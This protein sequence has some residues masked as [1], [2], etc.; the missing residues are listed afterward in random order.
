MTEKS[1]I[2]SLGPALSGDGARRGRDAAVVGLACRFPSA[3]DSAGFWR[4]LASGLN[5]VTEVPAD[6]WD[7]ERWYSP[8]IGAP[9][10]STSRWGA[11]LRG[12]DR[13]DHAFFNVSPREA[14]GMDP[15]QRLLLEETWHCLEDAGISVDTL[16]RARTSVFVGAMAM[17]HYQ[18]VYAPGVETESHAGAGTYAC[19][20]AN[21]VS[22][23]LGLSG[24]SVTL[25]TACSSS[26][27][28]LHHAR[29]AL[30]LD[31]ADY[32]LVAGVSLDFS[33]WK[34]VSFGKARMLSPTGQC[35]TFDKDAD[36][37]VPG[38][39][40]GVIL[41][42][43]LE[44]AERDGS[45]IHGVIRGSAVNHVGRATSLTAPR[46]SAQ[47]D[48]ILAACR[49]ADV[50]PET[51]TYVEAHGTGTSLGDP[52]E[53]AALTEAF[54]TSTERRGFC[55]IG[56]VKTN[57]GHLEAAAGVAGLIKTLL[58]MRHEQVPPTLNLR[59]L[60]PLIDFERS[61]FVPARVAQPW[62]RP[63][64]GP[65][66]AGVSSFGF[67][68]VN[69]H[70]VVEEYRAGSEDA[71]VSGAP[72]AFVLS[73]RTETSLRELK[74][75]WAER[76]RVPGFDGAALRDACLTLQETGRS[77]KR[78]FGAVVRTPAE[79]EAA[80]TKEETPLPAVTVEP[81]AL[82][83]GE[84]PTRGL[85]A[86]RELHACDP[87]FAAAFEQLAAPLLARGGWS[88]AEALLCSGD[89]FPVELR[90][91]L[92][93]CVQCALAE[94]LTQAGLSF[95]LLAGNT[96]ATLVASGALPFDEA[97]RALLPGHEGARVA[98]RRPRRPCVHPVSGEVLEPWEADTALL[99]ELVSGFQ[100]DG[101]GVRKAAAEARLLFGTQHT[102]SRH[103]EE[104]RQPLATVGRTLESLLEGPPP[105][106]ERLAALVLAVSRLRLERKW[107]LGEIPLPGD[108]KLAELAGLVAD[109]FLLPD[110]LVR[111]LCAP[112]AHAPAAAASALARR[113]N[114][115]SKVDACSAARGPG[116]PL[117]G[118]DGELSA[119]ELRGRAV[120]REGLLPGVTGPVLCLGAPSEPL[121]APSL[122]VALEGE[123]EAAKLGA[124]LALWRG[125]LELA[126]ARYAEGRPHQRFR[127]P[128][129]VF[130][131]TPFPPPRVD[132]PLTGTS[133]NADA[134]RSTVMSPR[135]TDS[136]SATGL[137]V[138]INAAP[139]T[140][141][142]IW[143]AS[144]S[145]IRDHRIDGRLLA[146]GAALMRAALFAARR[147]LPGVNALHEV[148]LHTP[149]LVADA[150]AYTV[151]T[152]TS[153]RF[154]V[155][156]GDK[157]L[158]SGAFSA[159][160][161]APGATF[162]PPASAPP[163][164]IAEPSELYSRLAS[165]GYGY[166]E[167]L[168]VVRGLGR[169][170]GK[171]VARL[172]GAPGAGDV[173]AALL[174]GIL[175]CVVALALLDG[176]LQGGS[177]LI[178]F[179]IRRIRFLGP[180]AGAVTVEL[181]TSTVSERGG[182]LQADV[183][184]RTP[185]GT[186]LVELEGAVFRRVPAGFLDA[187][188]STDDV[189]AGIEGAGRDA[190]LD[191]RPV[192]N[193]VPTAGTDGMGQ[194]VP[195]NQRSALVEV[196]A[197]IE[198]TGLYAPRWMAVDA[199]SV[200]AVRGAS[201]LVLPPRADGD[202][203]GRVLAADGPVLVAR[204]STDARPGELHFDPEDPAGW[205][206]LLRRA[207]EELGTAEGPLCIYVLLAADSEPASTASALWQRQARGARALFLLAKAA[208]AS[209]FKS[210]RIAV[211]LRETFSVSPGDTAGGYAA[212][213]VAGAARTI[214]LE[215][216]KLRPVVV[217]FEQ[218]G[219]DDVM[220]LHTLRAECLA[221]S[222]S[223]HVV[224]WRKGR[225]FVPRVARAR[226]GRSASPYRDGGVYV[227]VGGAGGIGR[228]TAAHLA[229]RTRNARIALV[230]RSP[231][232]P[233]IEQVIRELEVSGTG[234][235]VR[236]FPTDVTE[237]D[238][239]A[240]TLARVR[241]SLGPI[242]GV[243]HSGGVLAD[244]LIFSK[245]PDSFDRVLRPKVLGAWLLDELT[246]TEP[247]DF[248]SVYSSV[249]AEVGNVGQVD[250]AAA[251]AFLDAFMDFRRA[252]G[253]PGR[254][255][256]VNWTLWADGGMGRDER[257][258]EQ[259]A[260]RGITL[261]EDAPAFAAL[262]AALTGPEE[263]I[264]VLGPGDGHPFGERLIAADVAPA[265]V[266]PTPEADSRAATPATQPS[267]PAALEGWLTGLIAAR[268]G[269]EPSA[270]DREESFFALGVES[271][272]VKDIMKELDRRYDGLS[273]TL[274]F[275]R[276]NLRELAVY[277][278]SRAPRASTPAV[279]VPAPQPRAEKPSRPTRSAASVP[280]RAIAVIGMSGRFPK[281]PDVET[282]WRNLLAGRDCITEIPADRWDYRR[283]FHA[284]PTH[285][286]TTYGRW[287]GF[288]D[289]VDKFDP[290]FFN[291]SV[292]EAEQMD[293]QQ[294]LFLECAWETLEHAG[295]G[296]RK[297]LREA[298]VGLF[299]GAMWNEYSVITAEQGTFHGRYAGPGSLYWQIA[300][301]VSYFLDLTG[302]SIALDTAC[303]SSLTAVHLACQ[304][305][306]D[307]ES[308]MA[309]AGGV[310]LSLHPDKY[311]YLGQLRFLST[312]GRCR[313]FGEG[314]TGY[315]PGEGVGAVLLK[316]LEQA[317]ADGDTIHAV[318]R[319]T[320]VNHGGRASGFTVPN[321]RQQG[322]LVETALARS[323]VAPTELGYIECHGTGTAL[324]DPIEIQGLTQAFAHAGAAG[325]K[326]VCA[327]GSAKSAIGHLEAAAGIAGLI[328]AA[329]CLQRGKI[330]P[331]LH[332]RTKNPDIDFAAGPFFVAEEV[333]DFPQRE[334]SRFA[335]LSSFGAGG[336]NAHAILQWSAEWDRVAT[337]EARPEL[338]TL[339]A[340]SEPQLVEAAR[341]L[342]RALAA[343]HTARHSLRDIA[344][345]L[346]I[347]RTELVERL[348]IVAGSRAELVSRLESFLSAPSRA[349]GVARGSTKE[350]RDTLLGESQEDRDYITG[351]VAS[352][353]L[354][355][356]AALWVRGVS[357]DLGALHAE[358]PWH[359]VAL[360]T[361]PFERRR[362]WIP[363]APDAPP[364]AATTAVLHPLVHTNT[365]TL[366]EQRFV[367]A[368]TGD[369]P[370]LAHHVVGG[371][372]LLPAV[373]SIEAARAATEL[374]GEHAAALRDFV[375]M[376]PLVAGD[377]GCRFQVRLNPGER[378][379]EFSLVEAGGASDVVFARG[380]VLRDA[381][382]T[383][384]PS[385]VDLAALKARA[386]E[387][388]GRNALYA[389]FQLHGF[390]YGPAFQSI[391][392]VYRAGAESLSRLELPA[393]AAAPAL[394]LHP[395]LLDG[396]LQTALVLFDEGG[397]ARQPPLPFA[398]GAVELYG[399]PAGACWAW[400]RRNE[401]Q[402]LDVTLL[403]D[404]GRALVVMRDLVLR[405]PQEASRPAAPRP[406]ESA[407]PLA[408][409][410]RTH[411]EKELLSVYAELLKVAVAELDPEVP[412]SNYGVESVMMMT[413]LS[414]VE[415]LF[416]RAVEPNAIVEHPAIRDFATY[417][418]DEGV[419]TSAAPTGVAP[420]EPRAFLSESPAPAPS[421]QPPARFSPESSASP[422]VAS[423]A[424]STRFA[425]DTPTHPSIA[426][427][428]PA[429]RFAPTA[430]G[431]APRV[432]VVAMA[433]RQPLSANLEE[434]WRNLTAA[435]R[436]T[437]EVPEDRLQDF[438]TA[439][440][441][442]GDLRHIRFGGF[443]EG[444]DL[445]DASAFGVSDTDALLMDPQQRFLLELS[446]E[447]FD[448]A[449]YR[450]E[451][452]LGRRVAVFIGG[453]ESAYL[454][455]HRASVPDEVAGR[456][457]VS[458]IQNM[459]AARISDHYGFTGSS[460]TV[461]T[462]CS[463]SLVAIHQAC[464]DILSG[465]AEM[466][467]AGGVEIILDPF[468]FTGFARAGV[469]T[470]S[471]NSYV[472]DERANGFVL[473]EG[474]GLV[475]L[476]SYEAALR[477]G[478]PIL[479]LVAGSAVNNDG[480]TMGLTT[481]N[482]ER[483]T[484]LLTAALEASGL[485]PTDVTYLEAHGT[486][487][488]L[489]DPIEIRA[490]TKAFGRGAERWCALGSVKSNVG[491]SLHAAGVT[492]FL[493][494][495]LAVERGVLPAT[496]NCDRPHPRFRFEES[497]FRP[498]TTTSPWTPPSG[499]RRAGISS[500]GF[501]GTNCHV[502]LE[503]FIRNG[504]PQT[505]SPLPP[506][507]FRRRSYWLGRA[508]E[509]RLSRHE[510]LLRLSRGELTPDRALE[511]GRHARNVD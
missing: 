367:T 5:S 310:N 210:V 334:G 122:V 325:Q 336:S 489:G 477:D 52:V 442:P 288:I 177:L 415:A 9:N 110:E 178:P 472:F 208:G 378:D 237:R 184:A 13:F 340:A 62:V 218:H 499:V 25:D 233:D 394:Q 417:L 453:A 242:H 315:V 324:G 454:K 70:V 244:R 413:V 108:A 495:A 68:G 458:T 377:D 123:A 2:G 425:P 286:D 156:T 89:A 93:L 142:G 402:R 471:P 165:L 392:E 269:A 457:V 154:I 103:L 113:L 475:L 272:M 303:S 292:R 150:L 432:A 45:I 101:E 445:F 506:T 493:K 125:G 480:R 227:V 483:Q 427:A 443:V 223:E 379:L 58:M 400:V 467:I 405:R 317:L 464:R 213:G 217:D 438:R 231:L 8:D 264:I 251:N 54:R 327:I 21:R 451:E 228:K 49:D 230:G 127:L 304:S 419:A 222:G 193:D 164:A 295:Y 420:P 465:E 111:L 462:A 173:D 382:V 211:A 496:L 104:W 199:P 252:R 403:D 203:L 188:S 326:Q 77:F 388:L 216:K 120:G 263:R 175:Q 369:E 153:G 271:I 308:S 490:A 274:L 307:G 466:A 80:L 447:L 180:L 224:V 450:N 256:A 323:G 435:R 149:A 296:N 171:L 191:K 387:R 238:A 333:L 376:R 7:V 482:Q 381:P 74:A 254:S 309:L 245:E 236:Y 168:R 283:Y 424:P 40:V 30:L 258:I 311:L 494:T 348:A 66:R 474:A 148:S 106:D 479:A 121:D 23:H 284:D 266:A 69:S 109:E 440:G 115:G 365:S 172:E 322:R 28:A 195:L 226:L 449:G 19:M 439:G 174:D 265:P 129:Y 131:G 305:I 97:L 83:F 298:N 219:A 320:S 34:Y 423:V 98:L 352:R 357:V 43:R 414:R 354:D 276:P 189:P 261:L 147:H 32:C 144:D 399:M 194:D 498:N 221:A 157:A 338:V 455:R 170:E 398:L 341:R 281:A 487:T 192:R 277:L 375:W 328:K 510:L 1:N 232:S 356:L 118:P 87:L 18:S 476:K 29:R 65:L 204:A 112:D 167:S 431:R 364:T 205:T 16:A 183:I 56:S 339:S 268:I 3:D 73:A 82:F 26:L 342:H 343:E 96:A 130:D 64:G 126:W 511:L 239:L 485:A 42:Q 383:A 385:P 349:A 492:A 107:A 275:E 330:P 393:V 94:S 441:L 460:Q 209:R 11:F 473:G 196:P 10:R 463:S 290:L 46:V 76:V 57:I 15:Q 430:H 371:R 468:Y 273:P 146:P 433:G 102:F 17:D 337:D 410:L 267:D 347:G 416:G 117:P 497:P 285:A 179:F 397:D 138:A 141:G 116:T 85:A 88:S 63:L 297:L 444:I 368:L 366:R 198:G 408:T 391:V 161:P 91:A 262:D 360:P 289:D 504:L 434:F 61:P 206:H 509:E 355:K 240:A 500:F 135:S 33:P 207:T 215:Y 241:E 55:A 395:S 428:S 81:P 22:Y 358:R 176:R 362:C 100:V 411:V 155:R 459:L 59:T 331:N 186:P 409:A 321:P 359:R 128:G 48:V 406:A 105:G 14:R 446:R 260:A 132:A 478:D 503:Q 47:R 133:P 114:R 145:I 185:A 71:V 396:A 151:D 90:P 306:L 316:P 119:S 166:G 197:R 279:P 501:G 37:Y 484:E 389:R 50:A 212:A 137:E 353:N 140:S 313:S 27:V 143:R 31:E 182:D 372:K 421:A 426:I 312:D 214:A 384:P 344:G 20:M 422:S 60:N 456:M 412:V 202:A 253:R 12:F 488:L 280:E 300:N 319:G 287:G 51:L 294:R 350:R 481:P 270:V 190:P 469:L 229:A 250:Y 67:G 247:L 95:R 187:R 370:F 201:L 361:Y 373:A 79:L 314:G 257:A 486:G 259:L 299:V 301:R 436:L 41:L 255:L 386:T 72:F 86:A 461:D 318:I 181:A 235:H 401:A 124:L 44:D 134:A 220:L 53:V 4:N 351:L 160:S 491:H 243:I 158:C 329:L 78:R 407:P 162:G 302:P 429:S 418:I 448:A 159:S 225:R 152:E 508:G 84:L 234:A 39:G 99:R 75:K 390:E 6:R 507:R 278:A 92:A 136:G 35:R 282:Y 470:D 502:V 345:T 293:P 163:T 404:A 38:E 380:R 36:G 452:L 332:S 169:V 363:T 246:A 139:G 248:F 249:V 374:S 200:P 291:I 505:R 346:A 24:E 437:R 335:G